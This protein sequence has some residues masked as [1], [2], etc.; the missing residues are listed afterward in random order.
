[1]KQ[2]DI[3]GITD[4]QLRRVEHGEQAASKSTLDALARAHSLS[5]ADYVARLAKQVAATG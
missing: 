2:A 3:P 5:L 1:M 4:R